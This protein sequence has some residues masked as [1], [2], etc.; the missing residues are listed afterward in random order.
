[1]STKSAECT[2]HGKLKMLFVCRS[3]NGDGLVNWP[4][5]GAEEK[6]LSIDLKE[7]VPVRSLRKDRFIFVTQT[8]QKKIQQHREDVENSKC[9]PLFSILVCV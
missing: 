9:I 4:K 7:Q 6:H 5:Y 2:D 8:L 1:M 3:P